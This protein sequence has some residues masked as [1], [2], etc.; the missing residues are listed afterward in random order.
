MADG[1]SH[2]LSTGRRVTR[3]P[4]LVVV[5]LVAVLLAGGLWTVARDGGSPA[6]AATATGAPV[7][8]PDVRAVETIL[9]NRA[10]AVRERDRAAFLATVIG[11]SEAFRESQRLLFDNLMRLPLESW[12]EETASPVP[13][14]TGDGGATLKLTLRYRLRGFDEREVTRTRYLTFAPGEGSG[15]RIVGDGVRNGLGDDAD[16]WDGA[17][18]A[19]VRGR[20]SLVIGATGG[21]EEIAGR[22][23]AAVPRITEVV[24]DRWAR[25]V[26]AL[27]PADDQRAS[28]LAPGNPVTNIAA[29]AVSGP[30]G[31]DR[32]VIAPGTFGRLNALG[33]EVVLTHELTHVA[34]GGARDGRTPLWL[35][36]GLA[37]YVGYKGATV[38]VRSAAR[39]LAREVAAGRVPEALPEAADFDGPDRLPQ[40]YAEAWLACRMVA[41]RYGEDALV[42]LYRAAGRRSQD[43]ALRSTLGVGT[44]GFTAMW[45]DY[46]R[47]ELG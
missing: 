40:V 13:A 1:T 20:H 43:A 10:R 11:A 30:A 24:G 36:E 33:R 12:R 9:R 7:P 31:E 47:K 27:V 26:V 5:P 25:R 38:P 29:L 8:P 42:E 2:P 39:E 22:L 14:A 16:I 17:R 32:I 45:R 4:V 3:R 44:A 41:E 15:W 23:D 34:T 21:L 46:L 18:I 37:D 6:P 28:A 19:A 35:I